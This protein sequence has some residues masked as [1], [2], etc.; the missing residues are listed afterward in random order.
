MHHYV[1]FYLRRLV[2]IAAL[3][4]CCTSPRLDAQWVQQ[5]NNSQPPSGNGFF[6][7]LADVQFID[8]SVGFAAGFRRLVNQSGNIVAEHGEI[9]KTSDAGLSWRA[10]YPDTSLLSVRRVKFTRERFGF[11]IAQ[12]RST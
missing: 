9:M 8:D 4:I 7:I 6:V 5:W 11:L 2:V 12:V 10:T 1:R 3:A